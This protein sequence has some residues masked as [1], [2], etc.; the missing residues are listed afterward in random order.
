[1]ALCTV[2]AGAS[3]L[4][5]GPDRYL[6]RP[7]SF[8]TPRGCHSILLQRAQ[9]GSIIRSA[10]TLPDPLEARARLSPGGLRSAHAILRRA[11]ELLHA[12]ALTPAEVEQSVVFGRPLSAEAADLVTVICQ[13]A[14]RAA[15]A[16]W[17]G[18]KRAGRSL[19]DVLAVVSNA[20]TEV[21]PDEAAAALISADDGE[22]DERLASLAARA[23]QSVEERALAA[24]IAALRN[25]A[26]SDKT[27]VE[28]Y[29]YYGWMSQAL[30]E[31]IELSR[32]YESLQAAVAS[33]ENAPGARIIH[34]FVSNRPGQTASEATRFFEA[35]RLRYEEDAATLEPYLFR[36]GLRT[37]KSVSPCDETASAPPARVPPAQFAQRI[38]E[39]RQATRRLP[40]MLARLQAVLPQSLVDEMTKAPIEECPA[41]LCEFGASDPRALAAMELRELRSLFAA[42]GFGDVLSPPPLPEGFL[43]ERPATAPLPRY[44]PTFLDLL[45]E[46]D[47]ESDRFESHEARS[48]PQ[49]LTR[50]RTAEDLAGLAATG[51]KFEVVVADDA[52]RLAPDLLERLARSRLHRL[53]VA[54]SVGTISLEQGSRVRGSVSVRL[55]PPDAVGLVHIEAPELEADALRAAAARLAEHLQRAGY[56]AALALNEGSDLPGQALLVAS[57]DM[58]EEKQVRH[59]VDFARD[60]VVVLCRFWRPDPDPEAPL[61]TD[62]R[63]ALSLGWRVRKMF[64]DGVLLEKDGQVAALVNE[65]ESALP[66][67]ELLVDLV[68][69]IEARGWSPVV[70]WRDAPRDPA[71]LGRLLEARATALDR[72]AAVV[73]LVRE[74]DLSPPRPVP[75]PPNGDHGPQK[76]V[77]AD[78]NAPQETG[79]LAADPDG[80]D[81]LDESTEAEPTLPGNGQIGE[82]ICTRRIPPDKRGGHPRESDQTNGGQKPIKKASRPKLQLV[83]RRT[84]GDWQ[85]F[86]DVEDTKSRDLR[87]VQGE[88]A[89]KESDGADFPIFGPLHDLTTPLKILSDGSDP[90]EVVTKGRPATIFRM[91]QE[92]FAEYVRR[93]SRGLNLVVVPSDWRYNTDRSGPPLA[94]PEPLGTPGYMVHYYSTDRS[95]VLAFDRPGDKPFEVRTT[96]SQFRLEGS[97]LKDAEP[98]MG[99][100]FIGIPPALSADGDALT[101]I[102]TIVTA[103]RA[104]ELANGSV[105]TT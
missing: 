5:V 69:R 20:R 45:I 89:L 63:A 101:L 96:K 82:R 30:R 99:P 14:A 72:H 95:A 34:V 65:P 52:D 67:N 76:W 100:L 49:P 1:M 74:F 57:A 18:N 35:A 97:R 37:L 73:S 31:A 75:Q 92:D 77:E 103:M 104:A 60:G 39:A 66:T 7:A 9:H 28:I 32:Q 50:A 105:P 13:D 98:R 25:P 56:D 4:L 22:F 47:A 2:Q 23:D 15:D 58:A 16:L 55:E 79:S 91:I 42:T 33:D 38:R 80:R 51:E 3:C 10:T 88:T 81:G 90:I 61:S 36:Y 68:R 53:G 6:D 40:G 43:P 102:Q 70:C 86:V 62:A 8:R 85:I 27:L 12:H 54:A 48:W 26:P 17:S 46:V 84:A 78:S 21:P 87:I 59:L 93:P 24:V 29:R 44:S 11:K 41:R 94:E 19:G 64:A 83:A 71:E